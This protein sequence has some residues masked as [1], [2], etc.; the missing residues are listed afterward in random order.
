METR[1][2]R[3]QR[4]RENFYQIM[5]ATVD[6]SRCTSYFFEQSNRFECVVCSPKPNQTNRSSISFFSFV[7]VV[8][9]V[10]RASRYC[11]LCDNRCYSSSVIILRKIN[12]FAKLFITIVETRRRRR[13]SRKKNY[14][15]YTKT[16]QWIYK[17]MKSD[18]NTVKTRAQ[19]SS[20]WKSLK[21]KCKHETFSLPSLFAT[22]TQ[23]SYSWVK[24]G[25]GGWICFVYGSLFGLH[26]ICCEIKSTP[27][28]QRIDNYDV[29]TFLCSS[30]N[31][32]PNE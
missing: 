21:N 23:S 20:Q 16:P 30:W 12:R 31:D 6:S 22:I 7:V 1:W 28:H 19:N 4:K 18:M 24:R 27:R 15:H 25:R 3:N 13:S 8:V 32:K 10:A 5:F 11:H 17:Y 26:S 9:F 14:T 2:A 29:L